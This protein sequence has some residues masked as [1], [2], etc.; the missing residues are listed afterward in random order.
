VCVYF[1]EV[2]RKCACKHHDSIHHQ[3]GVYAPVSLLPCSISDHGF[4]ET[5]VTVVW[6]KKNG[7]QLVRKSNIVS[8]ALI[9]LSF[10]FKNV[11]PFV[12]KEACIDVVVRIEI[13]PTLTRVFKTATV[14]VFK[15]DKT[16]PV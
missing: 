2:K 8:L 3:Y 7:S 14:A 9:S 5:S 11:L 12:P 4:F 10:H 1:L 13:R 16:G 6:N 15:T